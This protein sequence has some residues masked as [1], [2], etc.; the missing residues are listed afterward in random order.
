MASAWGA[1]WGG[2]WGNAWGLRSVTP[3]ATVIPSGGVVRHDWRY[4]PFTR[5]VQ[6]LRRE[7]EELADQVPDDV[8]NVVEAAVAETIQKS[9]ARDAERDLRAAESALHEHLLLLDVRFDTAYKKLLILEYAL[10]MQEQEEAQI[11]ML[12]FEM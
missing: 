6:E 1:S 12:L 5:S 3:S 9:Y 10:F 11:A 8:I 4:H 7:K 2:A